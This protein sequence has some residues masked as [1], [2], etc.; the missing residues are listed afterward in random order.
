MPV[1]VVDYGAVGDGVTDDTAAIQAA[2]AAGAGKDVRFANGATYL[3]ASALT[4]SSG[5]TIAGNAKIKATNTRPF[6]AVFDLSALS[7]VTLRGFEIDGNTN[8]DGTVGAEFGIRVTGGSHVTL[9]DLYIHDTYGE[10]IRFDGGTGHAVVGGRVIDTGRGSVKED[11]GIAL[12]AATSSLTHVRVEGAYLSG[13]NRKGIAGY[14][15][16]GFSL[17]E[18]A[19]VGNTIRNCGLG[20]IFVATNPASPGPIS[21]VTITGNTTDGNYTNI[22]LVDVTGGAIAG[23]TVRNAA[24]GIH[25]DSSAGVSISGNSVDFSHRKG[26]AVLGSNSQSRNIS[27]VANVV[28]RSNQGAFA[29]A[30]GIHFSNTSH[31]LST[32]NVIAD[33]EIPKQVFGFLEDGG[34]E[35]NRVGPDLIVGATARPIH[36]GSAT[37]TVVRANVLEVSG[38]RGDT[39]QTLTAGVDS[40]TQRWATALTADR[41]VTFSTTG[42]GHGDRFRIVRTGLGD[43]T[44][45]VGGL[46]TIPPATAAFVD[47]TYDGS[48]WVLTGYGAL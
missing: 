28:T 40:P 10:G 4:P 36:V 3:V 41:T 14:S 24:D 23:N 12:L 42:V 34:S 44:L 22:E 19:I 43:F 39:S 47:V 26:I 31:S 33:H 32:G 13:A 16:G 27:V 37:T 9:R 30:A 20:G 18:V 6:S 15:T 8:A 46:K 17:S 38:D 29:S 25:V 21:G 45:D 35:N 11:H 48:S 1:N 5:T 2:L 7:G